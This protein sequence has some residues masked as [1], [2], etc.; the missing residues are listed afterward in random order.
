MSAA[1]SMLHEA[2]R[3]V[4]GQAETLKSAGPLSVSFYHWVLGEGLP[5]EQSSVMALELC[6]EL[7]GGGRS[8]HAVA[9]LGF[10][11]SI[12]PIVSDVCRD[13][14]AQ[15]VDWLMG[16]SGDSQT[17]L[18]TLMSPLAHTGVLVGLSATADV[19]R[20]QRF[21]VWFASLYARLQP[22]LPVEGGWRHEMLFIIKLRSEVELDSE[23][24]VIPASA[25]E[26]IYIARRLA[27]AESAV[28]GDFP[29]SLLSRIKSVVYNDP[30]Q[31]ALDLA[32]FNYLAQG[33]AQ[34]DLRAPSL[35]DV[36]VLL[37]RLPSGLRRWT[38]DVQKKTPNSTAQKWEI[39]NEYHFQNLLYAV[40]APVVPDLRDEEWLSS[41][42]HK[43]PRADL[44]IP[45]LHLVIEVK[46]WRD[47]SKPQD[48]ISQIGEDVSLYLKRGSPYGKV[49]PVIWDQGRRTEQY[50][51]LI[52][53]L[54]EIRDV[55][56]PVIIPQPA[57]MT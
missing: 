47:K 6:E 20:W 41:V 12:D 40:L 31:A 3:A 54:S 24:K 28:D 42:G 48:L 16:R 30:E 57:F 14:F 23:L 55:V 17:A 34:I 9:A 53:G 18:V 43:K 37:R 10:L 22:L 36:G 4:E 46:Y 32:A 19:V 49:L 11:L 13:S 51:L 27:T 33:A 1:N 7:A 35:D 45:S 5:T 25:C 21:G 50:D 29:S 2:L 38:W 52:A 26:A 15:G 56:S 44:V 39:E 8:I